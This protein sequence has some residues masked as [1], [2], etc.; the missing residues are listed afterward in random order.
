MRNNNS[1]R[2]LLTAPLRS[3]AVNQRYPPEISHKVTCDNVAAAAALNSGPVYRKRRHSIGQRSRDGEPA[4]RV[5]QSAAEIR[6]LRQSLNKRRKY[7]HPQGHHLQA[8]HPSRAATPPPPVESVA[9][10]ADYV[11]F[12]IAEQLHTRRRRLPHNE[13]S[14]ADDNPLPR[15]RSHTHTGSQDLGSHRGPSPNRIVLG[16]YVLPETV[17]N[18]PKAM[19]V[20]KSLAGELA[21]DR[22]AR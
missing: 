4:D 19:H 9:L 8:H 14:M 5:E 7:N 13:T 3:P 18:N 21:G 6:D 16:G 15:H 12:G 22:L 2:P 1:K 11:D 10:P 17:A 20:I